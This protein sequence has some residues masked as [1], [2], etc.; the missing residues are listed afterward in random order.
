METNLPVLNIFLFE[1]GPVQFFTK[2][3]SA[4][5]EANVDHKEIY[6]AHK[7]SVVEHG[8]FK[9]IYEA[10]VSYTTV[11]ANEK[12]VKVEEEKPIAPVIYVDFTTK[13]RVN[14]AA[15]KT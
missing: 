9:T 12:K 1:V 3:T 5:I 8:P 11:I 6:W 13:R 4:D 14:H 15:T 2:L 10:M 7:E